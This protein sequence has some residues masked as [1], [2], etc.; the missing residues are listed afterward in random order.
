MSVEWEEIARRGKNHAVLIMDEVATSYK[1]HIIEKSL[2]GLQIHNYR[3]LDGGRWFGKDDIENYISALK[4]LESKQKGS[5]L[6]LA[7]NYIALLDE[8]R[9]WAN[10]IAHIDFGKL[11]N[12][13]LAN[14]INE[15]SEQNWLI[16]SYSY[17]YNYLN[18]FYPDV[19]TAKIAKLVPD[20]RSQTE[21]LKTL[22]ALDRPSDM[23]K[24][25]ESMLKI[26]IELKN[27]G[28][29]TDSPEIKLLIKKHCEKFAYLGFYYYWGKPYDVL[30]IENRLKTFIEKDLQKEFAELREQEKNKNETEEIV[31]KLKLDFDS[32]LIIKT[33]KAWAFA[34]N[35]FDETYNYFV[36]KTQGL[37]NKI[38]KR[39]GISYNQLVSMRSCQITQ[40]LKEGKISEGFKQELTD[41]YSDHALIFTDNKITILTGKD[42]EDYRKKE[43]SEQKD[44]SKIEILKGQPASPG[45]A[46]GIVHLVLSIDEVPN[47]KKDEILVAA[48]TSP[49]FVPAMEK[50][51]AIVTDEG[52]L[53]SHAAIVSRELGIPCVVGTKIGTKALKSGD[54]VE[55][56]ANYGTVKIY[57]RGEV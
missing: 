45:L 56:N 48:S 57:R 22:F 20:L 7:K 3:Q 29:S 10:Q 55:I 41:R 35:Y 47:V 37:L 33:V 23:R 42:L 24:E 52:G 14:I 6:K 4:S 19:L 5:L 54:L 8:K 53:L 2:P 36:F 31:K 1:N 18:K 21:I 51:S 27:K 49:S 32:R 44:Y 13:K 15:H 30:E 9:R 39:L 34:A 40:A 46:S 28:Y 43:L 17:H 50:A 26:A 16:L 38:A 11:L 25:K 12:E